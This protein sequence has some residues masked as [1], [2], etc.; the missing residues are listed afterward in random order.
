LLPSEA[1]KFVFFLCFVLPAAKQE[2]QQ[3]SKS[4]EVTNP[5]AI[6]LRVLE[7]FSPILKSRASSRVFN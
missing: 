6:M 4:S 1:K 2:D 7:A 5:E 3:G